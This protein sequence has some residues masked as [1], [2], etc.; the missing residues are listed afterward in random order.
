MFV[1]PQGGGVLHREAVRG[2]GRGDGEAQVERVAAKQD[3][4]SHC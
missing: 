2:D 3:Q 1:G 4:V